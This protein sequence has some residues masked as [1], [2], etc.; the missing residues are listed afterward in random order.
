MRVRLKKEH[1]AR[2]F[3]VALLQYN[4]SAHLS[5]VLNISQRA[6]RDWRNQKTTL[7][8]ATY[9]QLLKLTSISEKELSHQ[10]LP[11]NWHIKEAARKGAL[12]RMHIYGNLGTPEGRHKGGMASLAIHRIKKTGFKLR[13]SIN[14]PSSSQDLAELMGI[15]IGDGHSSFYQVSMT[16][17]A[18]TD[19]QHALHTKSFIEKLFKLPAHIRERKEDNTINVVASSKSL[20]EFLFAKG[21]PI[22]NKIKNGLR[23]PRWIMADSKYKKAFIRGLFDTDGCV[24]LDKHTGKTKTYAYMG[25][26]ITSYADTL[27]KDI[28][29]VLESLGF[30]PTWRLGQRSISMRKQGEIIRYFTEIGTSN[31]KH[32][33][34]YKKFLGEVPKWS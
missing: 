28:K 17:N 6:M 20:V 5:K 32:Q 15:L 18:K 25:W 21:M 23:I 1:L 14:K 11:E 19:K 22:G 9:K 24:Y 27:M 30:A 13:K 12:A 2:L 33:E 31:R 8:H 34:R 7:P 10:L 3:N 16:T 26:T 29:H 4:N